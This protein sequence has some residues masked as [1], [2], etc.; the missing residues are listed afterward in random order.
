MHPMHPMHLMHP[1]HLHATRRSAAERPKA[2]VT[3]IA[4]ARTRAGSAASAAAAVIM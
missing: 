4:A 3:N 1:L 2:S